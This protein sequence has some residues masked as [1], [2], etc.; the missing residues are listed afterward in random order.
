[1]LKRNP[2]ILLL[3]FVLFSIAP[4]VFAQPAAASLANLPDADMLIYFSPQRIVR[5]AIATALPPKEVTEMQAAFADMKRAVGVDPATVEY[6][7]LAVR[8]HKPAADL[9]FVAPDVMVVAGGDFS[10]E[11]L[12]TLAQL[13][14]QDKVQTEKQG[15]RTISIM[16]IDE[17]AKQAEKNPVL[18]PFVEVA[19]VALSPNTLAIG[20]LRYINAAVQA[21]EGTG[22]IK[23]EAL[24]SLLRDPNVLFAATGAP[25]TAFARS[26]GLLGTE[27]TA[28]DGRWDSGFGNFYAAITMSGANYS[29]RGAMHADNPDTAKIITGLLSGLMKTDITA[30]PDKNAQAILKTLKILARDNEVVI[31]A[32]IPVQMVVDAIRE[33]SKPKT[34]TAPTTAPKKTT[35]QP[36]RRTTKRRN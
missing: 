23:P 11:S 15:S 26:F 35:R 13:S 17:V 7:V 22:R 18:K 25:L 14:L 24:Q 21:A 8:F 6:V 36:V 29:L 33:Q 3:L 28:R 12:L 31:E 4:A 27:T 16:K 5:D 2:S 9:S 34:Q 19:G 30:V 1:M 10:A 20:N 32:D